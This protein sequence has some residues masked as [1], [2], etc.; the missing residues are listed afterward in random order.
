LLRLTKWLLANPKDVRSLLMA[1]AIPAP[2]ENEAR[3]GAARPARKY[4]QIDTA[5]GYCA[6]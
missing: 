6:V 5:G 3:T 2:N 1:H 4:A